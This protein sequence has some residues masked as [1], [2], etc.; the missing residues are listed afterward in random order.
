M[1]YE[2]ETTRRPLSITK[3]ETVD[4]VD[5]FAMQRDLSYSGVMVLPP[6]DQREDHTY[7]LTLE[8]FDR[9]FLSADQA[10]AIALAVAKVAV[11]EKA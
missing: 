6:S 11:G 10:K 5:V 4:S 7:V 3:Y 8:G 9:I 1:D 2:T